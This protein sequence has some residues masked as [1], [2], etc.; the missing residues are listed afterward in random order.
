MGGACS[1]HTEIT[2]V[3]NYRQKQKGRQCVR[4][5]LHGRIILKCILSEGC[6]GVKRIY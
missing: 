3:Q 4:P 6:E 2:Y 1:T 5:G